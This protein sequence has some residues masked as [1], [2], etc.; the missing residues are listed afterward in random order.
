MWTCFIGLGVPKSQYGYIATKDPSVFVKCDPIESCNYDT[1]SSSETVIK[2]PKIAN[3]FCAEGYGDF[4]CTA[5]LKKGNVLLPAGVGYYRL[6]RAC[7]KCPTVD[8]LA[9]LG[10]VAAGLLGSV[11]VL[12]VLHYSGLFIYALHFL[13]MF[14]KNLVLDRKLVQLSVTLLQTVSSY[15][16][17]KLSWT[18]S[19]TYVIQAAS[20]TNLNL[21][22]LS[23]DCKSFCISVHLPYM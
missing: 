3:P 1:P 5:C 17:I 23:P 9:I 20:T 8:P 12:V 7:T 4:T 11:F 6:D 19:F 21:Q 22:L 18:P 16:G 15:K 2:D 13:Q 10:Y 14:S